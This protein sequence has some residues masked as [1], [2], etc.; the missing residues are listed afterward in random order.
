[1]DIHVNSFADIHMYMY[2]HVPV[3]CNSK[4]T[5]EQES[6]LYAEVLQGYIL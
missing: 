2:I 3:H 1:M 6:I 5:L 4:I